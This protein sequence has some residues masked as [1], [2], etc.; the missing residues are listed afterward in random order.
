MST[1]IKRRLFTVH[2]Y[3]RMGEAGILLEDDR[4]ELIRGEIVAMSPIGN[5]H[6]AA[7]DR[8]NRALVNLVG[9]RAIVRV[10]GSVRL[11]EYDEPQPDIVLLRPRPDFYNSMSAGPK[12]IFLIVEMA[13]S[14]LKYD[15]R[16]KAGLYAE[17]GIPEYWVVDLNGDCVLTYS[18][19]RGKAYRLV[20]TVRR[21]EYLTPELLPDC[22]LLTDNLLP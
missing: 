17:L 13:D 6:N 12:D 19:A 4:V 15:R 3:H 21:G 5:P 18:E 11:D 7:V 10:Q 20:R 14:S 9:D 16:V 22:T 1:I 8:A 2:D